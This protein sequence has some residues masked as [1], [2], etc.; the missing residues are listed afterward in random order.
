[1]PELQLNRSE[2]TQAKDF[3]L[4]YVVFIRHDIRN[5]FFRVCGVLDRFFTDDYTGM[6]NVKKQFF[7]QLPLYFLRAYI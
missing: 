1:M 4:F 5:R 6:A 3:R 7:I 2:E